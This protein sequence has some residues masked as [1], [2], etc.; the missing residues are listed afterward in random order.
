MFQARKKLLFLN[1][2]L[3]ALLQFMKTFIKLDV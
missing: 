1:D 2:S 3:S